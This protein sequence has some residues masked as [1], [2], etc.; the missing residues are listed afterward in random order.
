MIWFLTASASSWSRSISSRSAVR[1]RVGSIRLAEP[2]GQVLQVVHLAEQV[3][4]LL[5]AEERVLVEVGQVGGKS[6]GGLGP[7]RRL[8]VGRR[9]HRAE[10]HG[11]GGRVVE[12]RVG[13]VFE[14]DARDPPR[15]HLVDDAV[16]AR[17]GPAEL[18]GQHLDRDPPAVEP[19][20][21]PLGLLVE[22]PGGGGK[23]ARSG[24]TPVVRLERGPDRLGRA[25]HLPRDPPRDLDQAGLLA[26][27]AIRRARRTISSRSASLNCRNRVPRSTCARCAA[28]NRDRLDSRNPT[29]VR[30]SMMNRRATSPCRRQRVT[31][32][33][34]TLNRRLTASTVSTGSVPCSAFCSTV[35]ERSSTNSRRSCRTSSPSS[36]RAGA[37]SGRKPVIRKQ[38]Y[39]YG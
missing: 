19:V 36:T 20:D 21:L 18:A 30:P 37:P 3:H 16:D 1:A 22:G 26:P 23:M 8:A 2:V 38:R 35:A 27:S 14:L 24:W 34:E 12:A 39:S 11:A 32:R 6:L 17:A 13:H 29:L 33:T 10:D 7:A 4:L 25:P 31:V 15:P 5:A 9:R 28:T